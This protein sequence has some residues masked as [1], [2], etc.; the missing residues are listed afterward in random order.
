MNSLAE[1]EVQRCMFNRNMF[2]NKTNECIPKAHTV[3]ITSRDEV[4]NFV[5]H[6]EHGRPGPGQTEQMVVDVGAAKHPRR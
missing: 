6:G 5:K 1:H 3:A 2:P 4:R